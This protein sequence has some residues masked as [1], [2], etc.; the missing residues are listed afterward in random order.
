MSAGVE[1]GRAEGVADGGWSR[2]RQPGRL[3]SL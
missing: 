3:A 1:V 2:F